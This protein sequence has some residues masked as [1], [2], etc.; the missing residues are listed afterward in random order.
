MSRP[1]AQR[2]KHTRSVGRLVQSACDYYPSYIWRCRVGFQEVACLG[3]VPDLRQS[4]RLNPPC[5]TPNPAPRVHRQVMIS[6]SARD[7]HPQITGREP[8]RTLSRIACSHGFVGPS[9]LAAL[10]RQTPT[11]LHGGPPSEAAVTQL[12]QHMR[13]A[14]MAPRDYHWRVAF[15]F[16]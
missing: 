13:L 10:K 7:Y 1:N 15:I 14:G 12:L 6:P 2:D 11:P 3:R 5:L 9:R 16:T 8:P 4:P